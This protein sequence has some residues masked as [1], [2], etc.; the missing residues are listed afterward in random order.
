VFTL[1]SSTEVQELRVL[2]HVP[3]QQANALG[4]R[5]LFAVGTSR[6]DGDLARSPGEAFHGRGD[7]EQAGSFRPAQQAAHR[8]STRM[9]QCDA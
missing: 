2:W 4:A 3:Q 6:R 7:N 9:N 1:S 5:A 8:S